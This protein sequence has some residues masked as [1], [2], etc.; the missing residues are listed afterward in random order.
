MFTPV[1]AFIGWRYTRARR[2]SRFVSL[3][4]AISIGGVALGIASLITI[5]SIMNGFEREIAA[6]ILGMTADAT[7]FAAPETL[8]DWP[9]LAHRLEQDPDVVAVRPFIRGSGMVIVNPPFGLDKE[10]RPLLDWLWQAL[11]PNKEGGT[12]CDWLISE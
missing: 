7:L 2:R 6:R 3:I 8:R 12:R 1:E 11:S 5:L 9:A 10:A 4:S